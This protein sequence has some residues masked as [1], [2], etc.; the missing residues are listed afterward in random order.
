M[1][2][3]THSAV[4]TVIKSLSFF[5]GL[6]AMAEFPFLSPKGHVFHA[7]RT[8]QHIAASGVD[9]NKRRALILLAVER[10]ITWEDR[11]FDDGLPVVVAPSA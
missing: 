2:E 10:A 1:S 7:L 3:I 5:S 9:L 6:D 8:I 11:V 4:L